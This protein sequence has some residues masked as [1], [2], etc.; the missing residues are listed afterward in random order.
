MLGPPLPRATSSLR[1][2]R[3]GHGGE[4]LP[5]VVR[6]AGS[7]IQNS[8]CR[9]R[10]SSNLTA[11]CHLRR[12]RPMLKLNVIVV[13]TR[14]KRAG[15]PVGQWFFERAQAHGQFEVELVDLKQVALPLLDETNV[16]TRRPL[17]TRTHQS[18][19]PKRRR[20]RRVRLRHPRVQPL[21]GGP[22]G[23]RA[24]LPYREWQYK[25]AGFCSYGGSSGGMRAVESA[26]HLLNGFSMV[27]IFPTVTVTGVDSLHRRAR[28]FS[29]HD[30]RTRKRPPGCSTSSCAGPS[31]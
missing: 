24:R 29:G 17:R 9:L 18:L 15:L 19:E 1:A 14:P 7:S 23:Q 10:S 5:A 13:N 11:V 25:P 28:C 3:G 4:H 8:N 2:S 12:D 27:P 31:R 21:R 26:K 20:R 30:R 22:F 16:P 6:H